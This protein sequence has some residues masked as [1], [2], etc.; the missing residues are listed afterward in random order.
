MGYR[1]MPELASV[2]LSALTLEPS[3]ATTPNK[4]PSMTEVREK[5]NWLSSNNSTVE[6][7]SSTLQNCIKD[8]TIIL[9]TD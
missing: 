9:S 4:T 6:K 1:K 5:L 8:F 2:A 3:R 7:Y